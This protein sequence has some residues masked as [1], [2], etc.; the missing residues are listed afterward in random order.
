M[1]TMPPELMEW[2]TRY[3]RFWGKV[4]KRGHGGCWA[5]TG[6]LGRGYGLFFLNGHNVVAHRFAYEHAHGPIPDGLELDHVCRNRRCVRP[7]HLRVVD[8][9]TNVLAG[10]AP[11]ARN[12]AKTQ[13]PMGH[14]YARVSAGAKGWQR[15]CLIC[16]KDA[17]RVASHVEPT[18]TR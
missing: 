2:A 5:W 17:S 7:S 14:P 12:A 16:R 11:S 13:C 10:E 6:G 1:E 15:R 18:E 8:H 3:T 4:Q 9:R